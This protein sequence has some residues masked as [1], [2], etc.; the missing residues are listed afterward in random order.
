MAAERAESA[1]RILGLTGPI[2]CGKTTVGDLLLA[3]GARER[4]DADSVVHD[5]MAAGTAVTAKI[6]SEFGSDMILIDGSVD[7]VRLGE[8]VFYDVEALARLERIVHPA[9]QQVI[10]AW[11]ASFQ[12]EPGVLVVDAVKLLQSK[13]VELCDA[14]WVVRCAPEVQLRRL[15]GVRQMTASGAQAR[16]AAQPSFQHPSVTIVI[17]NS[18]SLTDLRR[19]VESRWAELMIEWYRTSPKP[20]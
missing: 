19:Q 14:V 1:P 11:I 17:E 6:R 18:G 16:L 7:R 2:A 15:M 9:V 13:L 20:L 12:T 3:L 8:L 4:I 10:R 5:L